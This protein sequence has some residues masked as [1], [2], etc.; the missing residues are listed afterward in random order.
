VYIFEEPETFLHENFEEY[1]FEL[2]KKLAVNNQVI[3]TTHSKKFVDVFN[4]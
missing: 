4:V 3:I 2:L 1:F